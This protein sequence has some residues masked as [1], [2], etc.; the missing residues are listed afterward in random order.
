MVLIMQAQIWQINRI[1]ELLGYKEIR[2]TID[3]NA[4][5]VFNKV[6]LNDLHIDKYSNLF[7]TVKN[8]NFSMEQA[9]EIIQK[10]YEVV[11]KETPLFQKIMT[12]K[13]QYH[14]NPNT[15]D[16]TPYFWDCNCDEDYF[17]ERG[18]DYNCQKCGAIDDEDQPDSMIIEV[19]RNWN[20]KSI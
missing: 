4:T 18:H 3:E 12:I 10:L 13:T 17:R 8:R 16:S 9:E 6:G 19:I 1:V 20:L 14:F 5:V 15:S 2:N 11:Y 7:W